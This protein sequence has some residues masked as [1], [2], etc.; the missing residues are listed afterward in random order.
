[1][2]SVRYGYARYWHEC[3]TELTEVSGTG[4]DVVPNLWKCPV[5]AVYVPSIPGISQ[6]YRL[7]FN[8]LSTFNYN[9]NIYLY[10]YIQVYALVRQFL[11]P[12]PAVYFCR[13][14]EL[15]KVSGTGIDVVPNLPKC[16]VSVMIPAV[17][18]GTYRNQHTG[19]I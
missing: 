9:R 13:R 6:R 11:V 1:M 8:I 18:L 10:I 4:I 15:N 5:L 2:C 3:R 14:T 7:H 12:V 17:Y 16:P 19:G